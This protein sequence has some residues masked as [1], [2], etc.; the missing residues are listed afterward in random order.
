MT[1]K[2]ISAQNLIGGMALG[3]EQE[4]GKPEAIITGFADVN[5]SLYIDY[6][7]VQ[8]KLNVPIITMDKTYSEILETSE[9]KTIPEAD[10]WVMTPICS[11]L[12]ML[13]CATS[14][15][16]ARGQADNRQNANMYNLTNL[17]MKHGAKIIAFENAPALYTNSGKQVRDRLNSIAQ[18][19]NY[20]FQLIATNTM[21]HGVPQSRRRTFAIFYKDCNPA[22][23]FFE[24]KEMKPLSAY[25]SEHD[26]PEMP[27]ADE[28]PRIGREFCDIQLDFIKHEYKIKSLDEL[29][30]IDCKN[31]ENND[32]DNANN[33]NNAFSATS[34]KLCVDLGLEKFADY[35]KKRI[36]DLGYQIDTDIKTVDLKFRDAVKNIQKNHRICLHVLNKL[37]KNL[38]YFDTSY[39]ITNKPYVNAVIGKNLAIIDPRTYTKTLSLRN[40]LA[41]MAMP[42]DYK[43]IVPKSVYV[44][45]NVPVCTSNYIARNIKAYF[46]GKLR[47]FSTRFVMQSNEYLRTDE[48]VISEKNW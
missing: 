5:D 25:L 47:S 23:F 41:L 4:F 40:L 22:E 15:E 38:G 28:Y 16:C 37:S 6:T 32:A 27:H 35:C 42:D 43:M 7:N 2:W 36:E 11:G 30:K 31:S 19:N 9:C 46:D 45:Q 24:H 13:N 14:G 29:F 21:L 48:G 10:L 44:T 3:F 33:A 8:R 18:E 26:S 12:S 34:L 39:K 17:A 1:I 20:G